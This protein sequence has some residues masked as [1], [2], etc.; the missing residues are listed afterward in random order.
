MRMVSSGFVRRSALL[1]LLATVWS[2]VDAVA[3]SG[4]RGVAGE[5]MLDTLIGIDNVV[6]TATKT[7]VNRNTVSSSVSV[8]TRDN[9]ENSSESALLPVLSHRIPG[10]FVTE[11]GM[12]GYGGSSGGAGAV[13]IRGVGQTNKVLMMFDGQ[14]QWAGLFGHSIPDSYVASDADR[15]EVVRGPGSLLYGSNAMGGVV[16][17]ITRQPHREGFHGDAR[18][19]YGSHNTQKYMFGAGQKKGRWNS[20]VSLNHDYTDGHRE[21]SEFNITNGFVNVGYDASDEIRVNGR[22]T[23]GKFVSENPGE[24]FAP[25]FDQVT[26]MFRGTASVSV[27]NKF[28]RVSGAL[29]LFYNWGVHEINDGY[30]AGESPRD[31]LFNSTD[32]NYG[33]MFYQSASLWKGNSITAGVDYKNWGGHAWND[34]FSG[35]DEEVIET[36]VTE[37]AAYAIMQQT[38]LE[39]VTLNAGVRYEYNETYGGEWVPQAGVAYNPQ[40]G[41]ALKF[42]VGKGFRSP[43]IRELY[44]YVPA[45]PDLEPERMVSYE[46]S[47]EQ[48]LGKSLVVGLTAF[49]IDGE[50]MIQMEMIDGRRKNM[51]TGAFTNKGVE[52]EA[53]WAVS[54]AL[55]LT[56]NYSY[57]HTDKPLLAAPEHKVFAEAVYRFG[58]FTLMA[59][60][61]HIAGLYVNTSSDVTESYTLFD[62]KLSYLFGTR[63]NG[64]NIFVKG[65]NLTDREYCIN[66]G[67]PMPGATV[68]FGLNLYF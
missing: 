59:D 23:L 4:V 16:N 3:Q 20:Y 60:M 67:F 39:K 64:L 18:I 25:L 38:L 36:D 27:E 63:N 15:V 34:K 68:M 53:E 2:F 47:L 42:T 26:D 37:A 35:D 31:Y 66:D 12:T 1:V 49:Y 58:R 24:T 28:D 14:P 40:A 13:N 57:L 19:M 5:G 8:V 44:M 51:N 41:T 62:A 7:H 11:R 54:R 46:A 50:N 21:N 29:Q 17:I 65:E 22:V 30:G 33:I 48:V 45:N 32:H 56:A 10:L 9:I 6:V 43:N 55:G 61:Q 52:V